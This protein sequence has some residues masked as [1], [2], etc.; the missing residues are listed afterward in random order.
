MFL[1]KIANNRASLKHF[2]VGQLQSVIRSNHFRSLFTMA[3][4]NTCIR[5]SFQGLKSSRLVHVRL[6]KVAIKVRVRS[7]LGSIFFSH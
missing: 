7:H 6:L 5:L 4:R 2:L 1:V 3:T